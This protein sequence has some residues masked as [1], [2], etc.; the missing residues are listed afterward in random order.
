MCSGVHNGTE[1]VMSLPR[2]PSGLLSQPVH[3]LAGLR[4]LPSPVPIVGSELGLIVSHEGV[5]DVVV[6]PGAVLSVLSDNL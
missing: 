1:M 2:V 4:S 6:V 5:D 3:L